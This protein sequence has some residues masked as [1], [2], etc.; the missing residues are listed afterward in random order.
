MRQLAALAALAHTGSIAGAA[1]DLSWSQPTVAHHLKSLATTL[2]TP[3]MVSDAT[4]TRL[5]LAG[6]TLLPTAQT[7]LALAH[8][9]ER[10]VSLARGTHGGANPLTNSADPLRIG[11]IPSVGLTVMPALLRELQSVGAQ[12]RVSE[13]ETDRLVGSLSAMDIDIAILLGGPSISKHLPPGSLYRALRRERLVLIVPRGH[14]LAGSRDV[15][16][17]DVATESWILSPSEFDPIDALLHEEA[18]KESIRIHGTVF[19]DDHVVIQ[20][21]VAAGLGLALVP[22]S[23]VSEARSDIEVAH[24]HSPRFVREIGV[25]V[26]PHAPRPLA[27]PFVEL[28]FAESDSI[29]E[30]PGTPTP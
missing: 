20:G 30:A 4:G 23:V 25:A 21:Y 28:L 2:D 11:V 26:A 1:R 15:T 8:R 27:E 13:A 24:M 17:T 5:T 10:E 7:I 19:S 29:G 18:R 12:V 16:L 6:E 14:R 9:A 22:E 3:I